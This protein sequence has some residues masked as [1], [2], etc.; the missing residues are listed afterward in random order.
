MAGK[1][2]VE[3]GRWNTIGGMGGGRSGGWYGKARG[4]ATVIS[5]VIQTRTCQFGRHREDNVLR[6]ETAIG[7][8][9]TGKQLLPKLLWCGSLCRP[10]ISVPATARLVAWQYTPF[11]GV[12]NTL[13]PPFQ[14]LPA[15]PTKPHFFKW[16]WC[17]SCECFHKIFLLLQWPGHKSVSQPL[18][19]RNTTRPQWRSPSHLLSHLRG[20][21]QYDKMDRQLPANRDCPVTDFYVIGCV[22]ISMMY[23]STLHILPVFSMGNT[24]AYV[25]ANRSS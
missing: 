25:T 23:L 19:S 14:H 18:V 4:S 21:I 17:G 5:T 12:T 8:C 1:W 15:K 6:L 10:A 13:S 24:I 9:W 16:H 7:E 20:Y 11:S 3:A 2:R 22:Q